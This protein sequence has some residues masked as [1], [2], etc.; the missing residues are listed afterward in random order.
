MPKCVQAVTSHFGVV[1]VRALRVKAVRSLLASTRRLYCFIPSENWAARGRVF[2]LRPGAAKTASCAYIT[3]AL[4]LL[5]LL[6][7]GACGRKRADASTPPPAPRVSRAP[8]PQP[9]PGPVSEPQTVT[10]LPSPQPVPPDAV[11]DTPGPLVTPP[12]P[13]TSPQPEP[14]PRRPVASAPPATNESA[15]PPEMPA[16]SVPQLG[17]MLSP[18]QRQKFNQAI[19]QAIRKAQERLEVVLV[20]SAKLNEEQHTTIKR[21]RAFIRQAEEARGQDLTIARNLADRAQLLAEDLAKNFK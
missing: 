20:N 2:G 1:Y 13:E 9:P 15:T 16:A 17:Q 12:V 6:P 5:A 18:D 21:I 11:P 3:L 4:V 8:R 19:D 7:V 14:S 10:E